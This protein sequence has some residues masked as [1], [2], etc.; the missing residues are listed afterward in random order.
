MG[1]FGISSDQKK[2]EGFHMQV[3]FTARKVADDP[4]FGFRATNFHGPL[5]DYFLLETCRCESLNYIPRHEEQMSRRKAQWY[6]LKSTSAA[7]R[8]KGEENWTNGGSRQLTR[9]DPG[10][11]ALS[12]R[13]PRLLRMGNDLVL[14]AVSDIC[15]CDLQNPQPQSSYIIALFTPAHLVEASSFVPVNIKDACS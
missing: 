12:P 2:N 1:M 13:L 8:G 4:G 7:V 11:L 6:Y 10:A 15:P 14:G 9:E 5:G 3:T